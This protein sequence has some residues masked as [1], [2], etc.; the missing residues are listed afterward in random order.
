MLSMDM[1]FFPKCFFYP[2]IEYSA[3]TEC[4]IRLNDHSS[5]IWKDLTNSLSSSS[6][7]LVTPTSCGG[8]SSLAWLDLESL[9]KQLWHVYDGISREAQPKGADVPWMD[10]PISISQAGGLD[11]RRDLK[12]AGTSREPKSHFLAF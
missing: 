3:G 7:A 9:G 2:N 6:V 8:S 5:F 1:F 11:W 4:Q 10:T 12:G